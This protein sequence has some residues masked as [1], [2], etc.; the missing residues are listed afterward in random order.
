MADAWRVQAM[1]A[2]RMPIASPGDAFPFAVS[3][4]CD[5]VSRRCS[6]E[7]ERSTRCH[8]RPLPTGGL[9]RGMTASKVYGRPF[10]FS[11]KSWKSN[12]KSTSGDAGTIFAWSIAPS[13]VSMK[14]M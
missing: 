11:C 12:E 3:R 2:T 5:A 10:G 8:L 1:Q 9:G 4:R 6:A 14:V 7:S 13:G